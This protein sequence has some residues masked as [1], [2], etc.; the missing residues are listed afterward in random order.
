MFKTT[1]ISPIGRQALFF[2]TAHVASVVFH[3]AARCLVRVS[4][5]GVTADIDLVTGKD[6]T[7]QWQVKDLDA[8]RGAV[9]FGG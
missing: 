8:L 2:R 9:M 4:G 1:V 3:D 7:N 5:G 6:L